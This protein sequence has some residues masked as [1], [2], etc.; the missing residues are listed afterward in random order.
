VNG[1]LL[2][3]GFQVLLT[4]YPEAKALLDYKA[5][6]LQHFDPG[7]LLLNESGKHVIGDPLRKPATLLSTLTSP[8]GTFSD[9]MRLLLLNLNLKGASV[10][11]IFNRPETSTIAYLK[12]KGFTDRMLNTF[13][14]PFMSG[15]FLEDKLQTSSRMFEFVFKMFGEG[16]AAVPELGM[17][18]IPCQLAS[19]LSAH[20]LVLN[21]KVV[22][23][24][25][26]IV[27]TASG[28]TYAGQQVLIATNALDIPLHNKAVGTAHHEALTVYFSAD[29]APFKHKLIALNATAGNVL[30]NNIAVMDNI[31]PAYA[32]EG[33]S[34]I[35]L[36]VIGKNPID[37]DEQLA[38][39]IKQELG[40]WFADANNWQ[41]VKT[42]RIKYA[43]PN[44]D[45]VINDTKQSTFKLSDNC[46]ICG[47]HLLNGSINAAMKTGR[48]AA[49]AILAS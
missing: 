26:A 16:H 10:D 3:H 5:L 43:L 12:D 25:G 42:Y 4:A 1:F 34:L 2:D 32:P 7:A 19:K 41:H 49:D 23:I 17:G 24:E 33:K 27:Q 8:A 44:D 13:F 38:A 29:K 15:I 37:N 31:A 39:M 11:E 14:K 22:S 21:E 30:A 6:N 20:E 18:M 48:L 46:F 36:S 35:G 45:R 47:D 40:Q 9:K 28:K